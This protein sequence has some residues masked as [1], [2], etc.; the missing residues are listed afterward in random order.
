MNYSDQGTLLGGATGAGAGALIGEATGGNAGAGAI[1][2][3]GLGAI[4]GNLIGNGFDEAEARN[5]AL[6]AQQMQQQIPPGGVQINDILGMTAAGVDEELIVNH[7]RA[8]G[9]AR[10]LA[11]QDVIAL[12]QRGVSKNVIGALQTSPVGQPS[13]YGAPQGMPQGYGPPMVGPVPVMQ[14][15]PVYYPPPPPYWYAPPPPRVVPSFY[16]SSG[17]RRSHTGVGFSFF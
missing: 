3:A 16:Y 1:I 13:T 10:P 8:N 9:L 14:P 15:V 2:G 6:I 4:T 11:A 17:G 5:R 12:Q 7:V